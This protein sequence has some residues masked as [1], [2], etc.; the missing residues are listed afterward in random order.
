MLEGVGGP[1]KD[2]QRLSGVE[3]GQAPVS[4]LHANRQRIGAFVIM[5][6]DVPI[7]LQQSTIC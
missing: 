7:G 5:Y 3:M 6:N 2:A 4:F 1:P